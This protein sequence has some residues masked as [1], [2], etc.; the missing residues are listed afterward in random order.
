M[1]D[2]F[3]QMFATIAGILVL[4]L[5]TCILGVMSIVGMVA[6]GSA[7]KNVSDNTVLVINLQGVMEERAEDNIMAEL[8]GQTVQNIGLDDMLNAIEKARNNDNIKGIYI[9]A[10][11]FSA[12]SYASMQAMRRALADFRKSGKWIVAYGDTY[13]QGTS[14]WHRWQTG[15]C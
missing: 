11:L 13:T 5:V 8:T 2:F 3:K 10:G 12:D 9:E 15:C 14:N 4:T 6:S 7:T 1:K